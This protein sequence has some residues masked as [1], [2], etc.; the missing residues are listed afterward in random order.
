MFTS[1]ICLLLSLIIGHQNIY[2]GLFGWR[3][4][5]FY[6]PMMFII[7]RLLNRDDLMRITRFILYVS[8]PM[9][10]LVLLQFYS[11]QSAWVNRGVGGNMEG[12]GFS[13]ALGYF[14]PPGTFSFIS[15]YVSYQCVVGCLLFY[16][17]ISN[18]TLE[19][20]YQ[21]PAYLLAVMTCCYLISIPTSISRTHFF[22]SC[23]FLT[24][25]F[26]GAMQNGRMRKLYLRFL[27][28]GVFVVLIVLISG[29]ADT[30][31]EAFMARFE[32]ANE[33]EG[34]LNGTLGNRYGGAFLRGLFNFE[35]PLFGY[36]IGLGTHVGAYIMGGDM[37]SFGFNGEEEWSRV[38]GECGLPLGW[39]ILGV[40]LFLSLAILYKSYKC[41]KNKHDLLPWM[42]SSAMVLSVPQG[43]WGFP[44]NLG[45]C[46]FLGGLS[47]SA[48]WH[49]KSLT[50][51]SK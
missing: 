4:Y 13:G 47:L 10:I 17:L 1:T 23:V 2:V 49:S 36:G 40:R 29:I 11:P 34:G 30:Q 41:L 38:T 14:R 45:F 3:I 26:F 9:T 35:L 37:F 28:L 42:L 18:K 21:I 15:G 27:T 50:L 33:S 24:F 25:A 32:S 5:F 19:K 51:Y 8:I 7:G 44:T 31:L 12:A 48:I 16:Y 43:Q 22:Q 39:I 46:I 6:F 20:R